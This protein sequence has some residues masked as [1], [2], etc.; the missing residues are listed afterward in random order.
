M[1]LLAGEVEVRVV[2]SAVIIE[3]IATDEV[4][5]EDGFLVLAHPGPK[6]TVDI[7]RDL[8]LGDQR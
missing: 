6:L 4:V 3:A 8:R 1:G 7:L 5:E 2:G